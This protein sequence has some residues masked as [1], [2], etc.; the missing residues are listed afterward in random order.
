MASFSNPPCIGVLAL[1][2][3]FEAHQRKMQALGHSCLLVRNMEQLKKVNA[4]ILPG[5]ESTVMIYLLKK[6][7][8]WNLLKEKVSNTPILATCSGLILL[9]KL[10]V[11]D[12]NII[13]NG[14]GRQLNSAIFPLTVTIA[15]KRNTLDGF[16]IRAPLVKKIYDPTIQILS[17]HQDDPVL[18]Q[19]NNLIASTFHPELSNSSLIHNYFIKSK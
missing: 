10:G 13:R 19:K 15:N 1:Q 11:L 12:I 16:F 4:L 14:Y 18:F 3:G 5:G 9:H 17:Y 2:G 7:R 6:H 8:L